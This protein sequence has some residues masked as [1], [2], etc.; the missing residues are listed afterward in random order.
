M[1]NGGFM[2]NVAACVDAEGT[3][4]SIAAET[5]AVHTPKPDD[6]AHD[7]THAHRR[8]GFMKPGVFSRRSRRR[9]R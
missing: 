6:G 9:S 8:P 5:P 3:Q 4:T 2:E 7:P 1:P